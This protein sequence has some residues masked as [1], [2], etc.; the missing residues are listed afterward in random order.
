MTY[1]LHFLYE[2]RGTILKKFWINYLI[3]FSLQTHYFAE[4]WTLVAVHKPL[5]KTGYDITS[6]GLKQK[7]PTKVTITIK[8]ICKIWYLK[9]VS[10]YLLMNTNINLGIYCITNLPE[11]HGFMKRSSRS[12][13]SILLNLPALFKVRVKPLFWQTEQGRQ[14]KKKSPVYTSKLKMYK[15]A[16]RPL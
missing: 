6:L 7:S 9:P 11:R 13:K 2:V 10:I 12:L 1:I 5:A 15:L 14:K 16:C 4:K 3:C 8:V